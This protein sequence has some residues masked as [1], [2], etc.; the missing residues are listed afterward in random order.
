MW[1]TRDFFAN[2]QDQSKA[3]VENERRLA[4]FLTSLTE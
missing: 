1:F 4:D 2:C 3:N